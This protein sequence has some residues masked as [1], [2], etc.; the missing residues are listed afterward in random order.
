[1]RGPDG[2]RLSDA[3]HEGRRYRRRLHRTLVSFSLADGAGGERRGVATLLDIS[4]AGVGI[5]CAEPLALGAPVRVEVQLR[6]DLVWA[7]GR[8]VRGEALEGGGFEVGVSVDRAGPGYAR[9]VRAY[10]DGAT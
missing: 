7:E 5:A 3:G 6:N 10:T 2:P 4:L 1:M 9:I 8:V